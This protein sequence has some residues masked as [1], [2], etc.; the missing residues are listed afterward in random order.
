MKSKLNKL[1]IV[2]GGING[3]F[4]AGYMKNKHPWLDVKIIESD[5]IPIIG[6]GE[7]V[8]PQVNDL[9]E[10]LGLEE[11]DWM[12]YTNSI[13]KLG[14][15]F[16]GWSSP[17]KRHHVTDHWNAPKEDVQ[18]Y[19]FSFAL[20]EK[21]LTSSFY[22]QL[23]TDDY[24]TNSKGEAG[25]DDKWNDYWLQ[26]VRE[27]KRNPKEASQDTHEQHYLMDGNKA[28]FDMN[29]NPLLGD[30]QSYSF[31]LDANRFPELIRD[32]VALP[33]GVQHI[34]GDVKEIIKDE[35]GYITKLLLEDGTEHEADLF[36]D[37]SGLH[38]VLVGGMNNEWHDYDFIHTQDAVVG[39]LKYKDVY[40]EFRPYTQTYA[41]DEGW[42]FIIS[43]YNRMGSGYIFDRTEISPEDAMEKF[44]KYWEGYEFIKPPKHISWKAGRMVTPWNKNVLSIGMSHAFIEPME[45][46]AMYISQWGIQLLDRFV[47]RQ[48]EDDE[49]ISAGSIHAYNKSMN[50]LEDHV[51]DFIAYHYTLTNREDTNFWKKQKE[52]GKKHNH[53]EAIWKEYKNPYNQIGNSL[54]PDY[55]WMTVATAMGHFD[56]TVELNTKKELMNKADIMF[57]YCRKLSEAQGEMAPHAYDWHRKFLFDGK[58]HE[59]VLEEALKK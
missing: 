18:Y 41:Q 54:Y 13:Y 53:K 32:K 57:E 43:L 44:K 48:Q 7:S 50:G 6:V 51:A 17:G 33:K 21:H 8:V 42:N 9:L 49:I 25:V 35:D 16:V 46:N 26:L 37:C 23:T 52:Y 31:H 10:T 56:D 36:V 29:D 15:K 3:W 11:R 14:N 24:F 47:N 34:I 12:S 58:S 1:V 2:G 39:P 4:T 59:E 38:K 19:S 40:N 55:M 28:P 30:W 27:G 22:N 5:T 45:G 20:P